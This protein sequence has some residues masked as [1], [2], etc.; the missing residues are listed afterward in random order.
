MIDTRDKD[1]QL[2]KY[3]RAYVKQTIKEYKNE[4]A[5]YFNVDPNHIILK[6][7]CILP[8][9]TLPDDY[10]FSATLSCNYTYRVCVTDDQANMSVFN[11]MSKLVENLVT[12][13]I[14]ATVITE[15]T[16]LLNT[17]YIKK[18]FK[19]VKLRNVCGIN[20]MA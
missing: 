9:K 15:G 13:Y 1:I 3:V 17:L 2:P 20:N 11:E 10:E 16:Y 18:V 6:S 8:D 14:D 5:K 19:Y 12:F 4:L 7:Q